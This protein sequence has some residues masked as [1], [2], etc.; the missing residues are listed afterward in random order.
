MKYHVHNCPSIRVPGN[1]FSGK[2]AGA[3]SIL[4]FGLILI[5]RPAGTLLGQE[6]KDV[7]QRGRELEEAGKYSEAIGIYEQLRA[8]DT[9]NIVFF[10]RLRECYV[11]AQEYEKARSLIQSWMQTH[12]YDPILD[13]S[14]AQIQYKLG[15]QEE[16][17]EKWNE[18]LN[19]YP[20]NASLYQTVANCLI[21]ERRFD[22]AI[23]VYLMGR[24][25][26][27]IETLFIFNLAGLYAL[28][29]D[30]GKATHELMSHLKKN[31][32]QKTIIESYLNGYP[33]SV[34]A[35]RQIE[36]ELKSAV[37]EMPENRALLE[38]YAGYLLKAGR[39]EEAFEASLDLDHTFGSPNGEALFRFADAVFQS[40]RPDLAEKAYR[41]LIERYGKFKKEED[42]YFG[43]ARC[44]ESRERYQE[45]SDLYARIAVD[46]R[47]RPVAR[48]A[49]YRKAWIQMNRLSD[50]AGAIFTFQEL[51]SE[52]PGSLEALDGR[53]ATGA[54]YVR[55]GDLEKAGS[56]FDQIVKTKEKEHSRHWVSAL[57]QLAEI[58]YFE[59]HFDQAL[60]L[61]GK[62]VDHTLPPEAS[63]DPALNDGLALQ[64]FIDEHAGR[65]SEVLAL[66][67][68]SELLYRK[69]EEIR[70]LAVL[71][72]LLRS[73]PEDPIAPYALMK[74]GNMFMSLGRIQEAAAELD[75][76]V[77]RFP[78]SVLADR[79]LENEGQWYE[80]AGRKKNAIQCYEKLLDRYPQSFF[81][82]E[83]RRRIRILEEESP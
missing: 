43:L 46:F 49:L 39:L 19:R 52:F 54:I 77:S 29:T 69:Q 65:N 58:R 21:T 24:R 45:A 13:I 36:P 26:T 3:L 50:P 51:Q 42:A 33:R 73:W 80:L 75:T 25:K 71:D 68:R 32:D 64:V 82:D 81:A 47:K 83:A 22:E 48:Q 57:V 59:G 5:L 23:D 17:I 56:L 70:S 78:G 62:L 53:L 6:M 40:G 74:R 38:V 60:A 16:A 15:R 28:R 27:G 10:S 9:Q 34:S 11:M 4:A 2:C 55:Q 61:L 41:R 12:P 63:S 79:A 72:T 76:L 1:A 44:A 18:I 14:L 37:T 20:K 35:V 67:A 7:L 66:F 30:Y 8:Q 31:P